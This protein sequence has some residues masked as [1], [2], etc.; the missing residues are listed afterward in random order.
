MNDRARTLASMVV[1]RTAEIAVIPAPTGAEVTRAARVTEWWRE[2]D[3]GGVHT[4][5]TGNVWAAAA[6]RGDRGNIRC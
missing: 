2:D 5:T 6:A 1:S 4:D 3:W